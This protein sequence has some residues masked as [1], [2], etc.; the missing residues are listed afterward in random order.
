VQGGD[1]V[2]L[3]FATPEEAR[4][5]LG[6][7][8]RQPEILRPQTSGPCVHYDEQ[9]EYAADA[10][11]C[12]YPYGDGTC[13]HLDNPEILCPVK[14]ACYAMHEVAR[15]RG[16]CGAE[17]VS[18]QCVYYDERSEHEDDVEQCTYPYEGGCPHL[19]DEVFCPVKDEWLAES[20]RIE[21]D[22]A[23]AWGDDLPEFVSLAQDPEGRGHDLAAEATDTVP[24]SDYVLAPRDPQEQVAD[25]EEP[26]PEFPALEP[27]DGALHTYT[28]PAT[29]K[30]TNPNAWSGEEIE[31][32]RR[33]QSAA[34]AERLYSETYGI[35]KRSRSAVTTRWYKLRAAGE[36]IAPA[37][38]LDFVG[39]T[40]PVTQC[41][42]EPVFTVPHPTYRPGDRVRIKHALHRGQTGKIERYFPATENYLV[43]IDGMP[44]MIVLTDAQMEAV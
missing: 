41:D 16:V 44:D 9:T 37:P 17:Q 36:L 33:A 1:G 29:R 3:V 4:E 24:R 14:D 32:I 25:A 20:E 38:T 35:W 26:E 8:T 10:Y 28:V 23:W 40:T 21:Q 27:D 42:E 19:D 22:L 13:P 7:S 12:T 43:A 5:L 11:P 34:E 2:I 39:D 6:L 30:P 15:M 31:V 18:G